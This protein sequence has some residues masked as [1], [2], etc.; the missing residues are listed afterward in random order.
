MPL[1][2]WAGGKRWMSS[3]I[4]GIL[5]LSPTERLIE[6]FVGGGAVFFASEPKRALLGDSNEE[7]IACYRG[8]KEAPDA[9]A[10]ILETLSIDKTTY[11]RVAGWRPPSLE[12]RAA[13]VIYLN[14][15]A[16]N[17]LWRV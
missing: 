9:V 17:G 3:A 13:R 2:K 11:G 5:N 7:L 10:A 1:L 15:T 16:F 8:L 6:P 12:E 4:A 14:R